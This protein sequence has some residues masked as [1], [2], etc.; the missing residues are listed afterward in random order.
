MTRPLVRGEWILLSDKLI[1]NLLAWMDK[2]KFQKNIY[3]YLHSQFDFHPDKVNLVL[4]MLIV[5]LYTA[6]KANATYSHFGFCIRIGVSGCAET[7]LRA[8]TNF[9]ES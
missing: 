3:I 6:S 4:W 8:A 5:K 2:L 9:G 7:G 1:F